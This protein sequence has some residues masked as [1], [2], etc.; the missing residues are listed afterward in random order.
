M[1]GLVPTSLKERRG[2]TLIELLVVIAIIAVLVALLL[3]A[4]QQAREAARRSQCRNNL[5]QIGTA[6]M[7]YE[8]TWGMFPSRTIGTANGA[9]RHAML[10]RLLGFLELTSIAEQYNF[11]YHWYET[12]N[13]PVIATPI[14]VFVCP[15]SPNG[16][17]FDTSS[18]SPGTGIPSFSGPRACTDYSELNAVQTPLFGL[19]LIDPETNARP[20]GALQDDFANCRVRDI[21]D[22]TSTTIFLAECAARPTRYIKTGKIS[23]TASGAGWGDFQQGFD[24]HGA[25]PVTGVTPG[26]CAINCTNSNEV[27]AFH[28][29]G[30]HFLFGDG[31]V[32]FLSESTSV[33]EVARMITVAA[34]EI[35]TNQ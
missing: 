14:P 26:S 18:Y 29:G 15:S 10:P 3:P 2:F 11:N 31:G 5:K 33:R 13:Q 24:L 20:Q 7:N 8:S 17:R 28:P 23:G 25:D 1:N 27:F 35:I 21:T 19:G 16:E 9:R 34:G 30:A 6:M 4:V 22:G 32:R 12:P